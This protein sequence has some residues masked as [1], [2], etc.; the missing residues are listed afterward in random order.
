[1]NESNHFKFRNLRVEWCE[2]IMGERLRA[3]SKGVAI[4]GA[5]PI[6]T[7]MVPQIRNFPF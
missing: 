5:I 6:T 2:R 3:T 7:E 4:R 1:M